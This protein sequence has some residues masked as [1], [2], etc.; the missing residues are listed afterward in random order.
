MW[1]SRKTSTCNIL[2]TAFWP[3]NQTIYDISRLL[4]LPQ[5]ETCQC[6][7]NTWDEVEH[8]EKYLESKKEKDFKIIN[9]KNLG[10][11]DQVGRWLD[12]P[13]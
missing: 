3:T 11:T 10:T 6:P 2:V 4:V 8:E 7:S 9:M 13:L 12:L 1:L 5:F